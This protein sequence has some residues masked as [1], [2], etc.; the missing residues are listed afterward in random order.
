MSHADAM[1]L[2]EARDG[3]VGS[4]TLSQALREML[5]FPVREPLSVGPACQAPGAPPL[6]LAADVRHLA[7]GDLLGLL[8]RARRSGLLL[9]GWRDHAKSVYV[10]RGE[11][12]FAA[13]NLAGDRVGESLVRSGALSLE[14]LR[15]AERSFAP[16]GRFGK[17][18]VELGHVTPRELWHGVKFQVEEIVRSLFSYTD[19]AVYFFDGDVKP[20]NVVRLSLPTERLVAE[21][22]QQREE[23]WRFV[24]LL[25]TP[26]VELEQ[27]PGAGDGL[28]GAER[29]LYQALED[30]RSFA[31]LLEQLDLEA[32]AAAQAI[33]MLRRLGAVRL[34]RHPEAAL[35][36]GPGQ[37]EEVRR[38]VRAHLKIVAAL[39]A[40]IVSVEGP[41]PLWQRFGRVMEELSHRYPAILAGAALSPD[42]TLDPD[43]LMARALGVAGDPLEQVRVALGELV[44][45]LEFELKNHPAIADATPHLA[46]ADA[47]RAEL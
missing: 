30:E 14:A 4:V 35:A 23:L 26:G 24:E 17:V 31:G 3:P 27:V 15:L 33:Q 12:V 21:G 34:H 10:H 46:G 45:Y 25:R 29:L 39:A 42:A 20:D 37:D 8:H 19:G 38:S 9:F 11:L 7:I 2:F 6:A 41:G 36:D 28:E 47:L 18:L 22:M 32:R 44:S 16:G 1:A 13:S 5:P 40:P 43:P